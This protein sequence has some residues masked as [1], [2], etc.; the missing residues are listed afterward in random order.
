M[1][2]SRPKPPEFVIDTDIV[3]A[4][5]GAFARPAMPEEPIETQLL[6]GWMA[7][8]WRWVASEE[9]VAEYAALLIER[10][11]PEPRVFRAIG[12]IRDR[13]R[14]VVPRP[15]TQSLPDPGDAHVIGTVLAGGVPIATRNVRHYP[16]GR[17]TVLSP[18]Q[19]EER[20]QEYLRHPMVRQR[21]E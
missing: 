18:Q 1:S 11:A 10:G 12:A 15:V 3:V 19:M 4:G 2:P 16:T 13:A 21:R 17:V 6:R 8:Q 5:A 7:R 14:I 20:V 9:L